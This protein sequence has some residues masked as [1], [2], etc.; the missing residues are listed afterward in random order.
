MNFNELPVDAKFRF[1]RRGTLLTKTSEGGY[2]TPGAAEQKAAPDVEVIP[3]EGMPR[4][5]TRRAAGGTKDPP[6]PSAAAAEQVQAAVERDEGVLVARRRPALRGRC[7][8]GGLRV[9]ARRTRR[10]CHSDQRK[11]RQRQAEDDGTPS[12]GS[13]SGKRLRGHRLRL[14]GRGD[15]RSLPAA[16]H[17]PVPGHPCDQ[18]PAG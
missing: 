9:H 13:A 17:A 6:R 11:T 12:R 15:C 10:T 1:F 4:P 3:E 7:R 16:T 2:T 18:W 5:A 14:R 8:P